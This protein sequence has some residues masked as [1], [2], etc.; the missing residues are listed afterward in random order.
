MNNY[1]KLWAKELL[2]KN[3]IKLFTASLL[4]FIMRWGTLA[5]IVLFPVIFI[6]SG[7]FDYICNYIGTSLGVAISTICY[8]TL[9]F[10]LLCFAS[11]VGLGEQW[12]Y[13]QRL[14]GT[15][16]KFR[17]LFKFLLPKKSVRAL[18]LYIKSLLIKSMWL[19]YFIIPPAICY[20]CAHFLTTQNA[21]RITVFIPTLAGAILS[22]TFFV[23]IKSVFAR[24]SQAQYY[25]CTRNTTAKDAINLSIEST[26]GYLNDRTVLHF[27][28]IGW[29]LSCIFIIPVIYAVPY[30]KLCN[31]V[32]TDECCTCTQTT[33][34]YAVNILGL[35]PNI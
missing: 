8:I 2:Y 23:L 15:K 16:V 29:V 31:A 34:K 22:S 24:Y 32:F 27:T 18:N 30:I 17:F 26:D 13:L 4:S 6:N 11:G 3:T 10:G 7:A 33:T 14:R 9:T 28:L 21:D 35:Q 25:M 5:L 12:I 1:V 20:G 19:V